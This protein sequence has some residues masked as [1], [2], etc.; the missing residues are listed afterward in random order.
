ME[1]LTAEQELYVRQVIANRLNQMRDETAYTRQ[2]EHTKG[3]NEA[4][5]DAVVEV[6]GGPPL[7]VPAP[8]TM[9]DGPGGGS[10]PERKPLQIFRGRIVE[11][12]ELPE[13]PLSDEDQAYADRWGL[14]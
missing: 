10:E 4:L 3:Y 2:S 13:E 9:I 12:L 8:R 1:P 5:R 11:D 14:A 7:Y 6:M